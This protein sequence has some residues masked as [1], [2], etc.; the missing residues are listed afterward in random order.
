MRVLG[1]GIV[2][3]FKLN[4]AADAGCLAAKV[5]IL[6]DSSFN[7]KKD[8]DII[9]KVGRSN[10]DR[11]GNTVIIDACGNNVRILA[12]INYKTRPTTLRIKGVYTHAEYDK[13]K[14]L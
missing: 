10:F 7:P 12:T 9:E 4:H 6:K 8:L 1:T 11:V 3:K 13:L 2:T 14:F 5:K